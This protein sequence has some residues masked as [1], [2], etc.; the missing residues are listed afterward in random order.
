MLSE[1]GYLQVIQLEHQQH[2]HQEEKNYITPHMV[3]AIRDPGL[4]NILQ[5]DSSL[6]NETRIYQKKKKKTLYHK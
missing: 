5:Y 4:Y 6:G 3:V 1:Y 2:H